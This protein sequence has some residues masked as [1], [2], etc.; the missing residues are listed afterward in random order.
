[1][2]RDIRANRLRFDKTMRVVDRPLTVNDVTGNAAKPPAGLIPADKPDDE[3]MQLI[4][5]TH[6]DSTQF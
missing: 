1:M 2:R 6:G 3:L 5:L 4:I